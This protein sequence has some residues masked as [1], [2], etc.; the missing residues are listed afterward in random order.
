MT[1][2]EFKVPVTCMTVEE[3]D[4]STVADLARLTG[5][6]VL[7]FENCRR[8]TG[9]RSDVMEVKLAPISPTYNPDTLFIRKGGS[10]LIFPRGVAQ[11]LEKTTPLFDYFADMVAMEVT[12]LDA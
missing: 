7:A 2:Y 9:E 1:N 4:F 12:G 8:N 10:I 11:V 5:R 6:E 3:V